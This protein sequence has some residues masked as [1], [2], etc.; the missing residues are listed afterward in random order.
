[1]T[2]E[3]RLHTLEC[4]LILSNS[5]RGL[6]LLAWDKKRGREGRLRDWLWDWLQEGIDVMEHVFIE[7][8]LNESDDYWIQSD[9]A[10][11]PFSHEDI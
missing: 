5:H 9:A 1:M 11:A 8:I 2:S 4:V 6:S 7:L 3:K 10:Q